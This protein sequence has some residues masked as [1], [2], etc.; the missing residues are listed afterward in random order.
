[1]LRVRKCT[2]CMTKYDTY[3][4][5]ICSH[6]PLC[7]TFHLDSV[8]RLN[9]FNLFLWDELLIIFSE[10]NINFFIIT[11]SLLYIIVSLC[12]RSGLLN[13]FDVVLVAKLS[14]IFS[15]YLEFIHVSFVFCVN[16]FIF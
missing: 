11:F 7:M 4:L 13:N 15:S 6:S 8:V 1:M 16:I 14:I 10:F 9:K 2:S 12:D 5:Y 3:I